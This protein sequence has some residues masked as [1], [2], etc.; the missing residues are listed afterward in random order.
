MQ[1]SR[2]KKIWNKIEELYQDSSRKRGQ[3]PSFSL[4][5]I[6]SGLQ[7][8][9]FKN[10]Y[11]AISKEQGEYIYNFILEKKL[12]KV[13]EFGT[14]FGISTLFLAAAVSQNNGQVIATELLASKAKV[15]QKNFEHAGVDDVIDLRVGDAMQTLSQNV[16]EIDFLFLDGWKD[17]YLPLLHQLENQLVPGAFV[18]VD[19]ANMRGVKPTLQYL[20]KSSN[21]EV[22]TLSGGKA[23]LAKKIGTLS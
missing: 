17:L 5:S 2:D 21:Y 7:P 22:V 3:W 14:S 20:N 15:A 19:N 16:G 12:K 23:V 18:Y 1:Q 4:K 10:H 6:K 8:E 11:L 9:D 13:V